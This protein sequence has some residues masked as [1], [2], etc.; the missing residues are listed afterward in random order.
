MKLQSCFLLFP[1]PPQAPI[2]FFYCPLP[3]AAT[4]Y[5]VNTD[6]LFI[7]PRSDRE[8][9]LLYVKAEAEP[10]KH[11]HRVYVIHAQSTGLVTQ[12][13]FPRYIN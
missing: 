6:R 12:T 7:L 1:V 3:P 13:L 8:A 2:L 9:P 10:F 4:T 11:G 5:A